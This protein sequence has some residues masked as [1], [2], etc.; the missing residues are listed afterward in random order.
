MRR[1]CTVHWLKVPCN[2]PCKLKKI[3][4]AMLQRMPGWGQHPSH[5][6]PATRA[7]SLLTGLFLDRVL[8]APAQVELRLRES[9]RSPAGCENVP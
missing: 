5:P 6:H 3:S 8:R 1:P 2:A 9:Y 4:S 7:S